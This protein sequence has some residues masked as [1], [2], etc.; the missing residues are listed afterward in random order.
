MK[1]LNSA[2][3]IQEVDAV[4][5]ASVGYMPRS[6]ILTTL[7]H[8]KPV[9]DNKEPIYRYTRRNGNMVLSMAT[10]YEK[11]LPFGSIP[12]LLIAQIATQAKIRKTKEIY[13]GKNLAQVL[14]NLKLVNGG[15][16]ISRLK[17]QLTALFSTMITTREEKPNASSGKNMTMAEEWQLY[18]AVDEDTREKK[19]K[20]A[21]TI[22]L[23][24]SFYKEITT[25][26]VPID[27]RALYALSRSPMSMDIYCWLTY[28]FYG[29]RESIMIPWGTLSNQ[30]GSEYKLTRQFK[31]A[32][33]EQLNIVKT[34]YPKAIVLNTA[35]GLVLKP[36][37][38]HVPKMPKLPE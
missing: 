7:P 13:L 16:D 32:F 3:E 38:T 30:F 23:T 10:T 37:P 20:A 15:S 24:E 12:R 17:N 8:R 29:L 4:T 33:L 27:L 11:G 26:A 34:L 22:T 21:C 18:W 31:A 14:D 19:S 6:L 2:C 25:I 28:R 5:A 36:S 9:G 1:F 35:P